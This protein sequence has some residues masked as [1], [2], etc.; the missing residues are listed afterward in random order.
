LQRGETALLI[1]AAANNT[2]AVDELLRRRADPNLHEKGGDTPLFVSLR[3]RFTSVAEALLRDDRT[4]LK[5][6]HGGHKDAAELVDAANKDLVRRISRAQAARRRLLAPPKPP[7]R[8]PCVDAVVYTMLGLCCVGV[9]AEV[10]SAFSDS[11]SFFLLPLFALALMY[12]FR[13]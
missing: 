8:R 7:P 12:S 13:G 3:R 2:A 11:A 1:A 9:A 6:A 4:A 5:S 10:G